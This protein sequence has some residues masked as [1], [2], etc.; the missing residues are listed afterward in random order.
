MSGIH[1][2]KNEQMAAALACIG[3]GVISTDTNGIIEF[4]NSSAEQLTGWTAAEAVG[5]AFDEVFPIVNYDTGQSVLSP[6]KAALKAGNAVGLENRS[7]LSLKDGSLSYISAN[8]SPIKSKDGAVTGVVVVFR[9]ITRIKTMEAELLVEKNNLQMTFEYAPVGMLVLDNNT[10]IKQANNAF[11]E[12]L[13]FDISNVLE[14]QFGDGLS[15]LNSFEKGCGVGIMCTLCELRKTIKDV[16]KS[17]MPCKDIIVQHTLLV[18]GKEISPWYKINFVPVTIANKSHVLVVI[19]DIT[20]QKNREEQLVRS[21]N[22]W[23]KMM[24]DFPAMIWR[25]DSR[26]NCDYLNKPWLDF[27]GLTMEQG[28]GEGW[29]KALHKN[30]VAKCSE[31]LNNA[32]LNQIPF[33]MEHRMLRYDG[34]YR[35]VLSQ[36]TPYYDLEGDFAGF[37]GTVYDITERKKAD[38]DL[39][40]SEEKFKSLFNKVTDAIYLHELTEDHGTVSRIVE[41]NDIAC[42]TLGYTR[43]ELIGKSLLDINNDVS[44]MV[45]REMI[46]AVIENGTYTYEAVHLSKGG[47]EIPVEVNSHY[48][49]MDDRKLILSVARDITERKLAERAIRDSEERY[50]S[51]FMNMH[52]NLAYNK[53]IYDVNGKPVDF[54]IIEINEAC[55]KLIGK[56]KADVVGKRFSQLFTGKG[57]LSETIKLCGDVAINGTTFVLPE[58]FSEFLGG[59]F[60]LALYSPKKGYFVVILTDITQQN[61]SKIELQKA[62]EQAEAANKAKSEFLANM[63]HEIRTPLN[64]IVGM[65]DLTLMTNVDQE[66]IENLTTA[67]NCAGSLLRIINDILDFSKMEAGKLCFENVNFDI[68]ELLNEITRAHSVGASNKGLELSYA[69]S[70][71][72]PQYLVGDPSRLKQ[73]LDNLLSNAIKF[74]NRGEVVIDIKKI[75]QGEGWTELRFSVVDTGIG[76]SAQNIDKLFKSFS[77]IDSTYTKKVGGTGLG[78]IISKQLAEMMGGAMWVESK[79]GVGSSF[80]FKIPLKIG[81]KLEKPQEAVAVERKTAQTR[82]ILLVEDDNVNQIVLSRML[83]ENGYKVDIV[84]NGLEALDAHKNKQYDVILMDIQMPLMDGIEATRRIREKELGIGHTL[85]IALTAFALQG[86]RER[87]LQLGMDG[88]IS[89]PVKMEDLFYTIENVIEASRQGEHSFNERIKIGDD[90]EL[91]FSNTYEAKDNVELYP[92]IDE[93]SEAIK[94]IT[95]DIVTED[96]ILIEESAHQIKALFNQ[97]EAEEMKDIAFKIELSARRGN[98]KEAIKHILR[99]NYEFKTYKKTL[100]I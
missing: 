24:D 95:R 15:C 46:C 85:I 78:L 88:Y 94:K 69:M 83:Q 50:Y 52:N 5:K 67:K 99:I 80:Y 12:M 22:Y 74:T 32:L 48:Y 25:C 65:I 49:V 31:V 61:L 26:K 71:N 51:L 60:S 27:V 47:K 3:D 10:V 92:I 64:G 58:F 16:L 20:D 97:I 55:E 40:D 21:K 59:W 38:K 86:D 35:W 98:L 7:A 44:K 37:V 84:N 68:K 57:E 90:G 82:N 62:K 4:I 23:L 30:D 19:D 73:I 89:K 53:I 56:K 77:Q 63:S 39:R 17:G 18:D 96:L 6:I 43:E 9:D 33:E 2:L 75:T 1:N 70:S 93:L 8:S 41:I 28:M 100:N 45:K 54:E 42:N 87:F 72:I 81:K 36:G 29:V 14:Q 66:Q 11:L 76:I 79:E 91:V 13:E 34:E